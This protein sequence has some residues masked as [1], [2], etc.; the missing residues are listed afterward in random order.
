V[1][2][3]DI[4]RA[5]AEE[6]HSDLIGAPI[7]SR[8]SSSHRDREMGA[9]DGVGS[10]HALVHIGQVHRAALAAHQAALA[11]HELAQ[12]ARHRGAPRQRMRVAPIRAETPVAGPHRRTECGGNR[13]LADRQMAGALDQIL[14]KQ[15]IGA[16]LDRANLEL[17]A[18][19]SQPRRRVD[20]VACSRP[21]PGRRLFYLQDHILLIRCVF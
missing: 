7:L 15:I 18:V 3:A 8:P 1:E 21:R 5:V 9:D 14:E 2:R 13:L 17:A 11:S 10:H 20:L 16:L 6:A 19:Q 4:G 12:Y